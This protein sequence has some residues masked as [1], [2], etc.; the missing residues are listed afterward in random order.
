[1]LRTLLEQL[2]LLAASRTCWMAGNS[3][4]ISMPMMAITTSNSTNVNARFCLIDFSH[5]FESFQSGSRRRWKWR[6]GG[7]ERE[8]KRSRRRTNYIQT[9]PS[10]ST[11]CSS[12][13]PTEEKRKP[14]V[15]VERLRTNKR[16]AKRPSAKRP[17]IKRLGNFCGRFDSR[18]NF[19]SVIDN[20]L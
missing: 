4:P 7:D 1:M 11:K 2:I 19:A 8:R 10:K 6:H 9:H 20:F 5:N 17:S 13:F 16:G 18:S 14:P 15:V 3:M 12:A